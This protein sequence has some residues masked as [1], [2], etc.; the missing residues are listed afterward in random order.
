MVFIQI[1]THKGNDWFREE[2]IM[3]EPSMVILIEPNKDLIEDI[4]QNYEGIN[5]VYIEN[6]A[7]TTIPGDVTLYLPKLNEQ[8]V[9]S[10]GVGYF[11]S[12]YSLLPMDDW[13]D[14]K[15]MDSFTAQGVTFD[16]IL[17]KYK[18]TH[19]NY[20]CIDTEGYDAEIIKS[21]DFDKV[22]IDS[23]QYEDWSFSE[24]CFRRYGDDAKRFGINAMRDV[25]CLLESYGYTLTPS[26]ANI[27]AVK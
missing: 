6:V 4:K 21:I 12:N 16:S 24:D 25:A 20:L 2:V 26:G 5:G 14:T 7:I 15:D 13:G 10:N 18:I 19:I 27:I 22:K 23:L 1:G 11:P 17:D 3:Y 9:A 8:G